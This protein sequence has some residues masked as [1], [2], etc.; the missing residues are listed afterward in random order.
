MLCVLP[1]IGLVR[2]PKL[3]QVPTSLA[4]VR[5]VGSGVLGFTAWSHFALDTESGSWRIFGVPCLGKDRGGGAEALR[6]HQNKESVTH[7][8]ENRWGV[9]VLALA[10]FWWCWPIQVHR[11]LIQRVGWGLL[12]QAGRGPPAPHPVTKRRY[13]RG[14]HLEWA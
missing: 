7:K 2:V 1:A 9:H 14:P 5:A 13:Q 10:L 12:G 8:C 4:S 6:T 3:V 11:P